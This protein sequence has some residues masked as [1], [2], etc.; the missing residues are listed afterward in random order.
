MEKRQDQEWRAAAT[1]YREAK[2]ALEDAQQ[3]ERDAKRALIELTDADAA[4]SGVQVKFSERRG[5]VDYKAAV[6][7]LMPDLDPELYRKPSSSVT[8][9]SIDKE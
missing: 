1:A 8:T 3:A 2:M 5:S 6:E 7:E 9:V 4:G